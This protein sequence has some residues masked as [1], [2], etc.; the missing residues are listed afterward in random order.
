[1]KVGHCQVLIPKTPRTL[2]GAGGFSFCG[3]RLSPGNLSRFWCR[4]SFLRVDSFIYDLFID[5]VLSEVELLGSG[6]A[7]RSLKEEK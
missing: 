1:M 2:I 3:R 7:A 6:L 4:S 5:K